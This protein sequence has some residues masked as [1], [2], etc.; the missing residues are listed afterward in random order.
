[1]ARIAAVFAVTSLGACEENATQSPPP[2]SAPA[3]RVNQ[4]NN[5]EIPDHTRRSELIG[6]WLSEG[7][8]AYEIREEPDGSVVIQQQENA[9]WTYVI[10][11]VRW[12]SDRLRFDEYAIYK[13]P[14]EL[15][16]LRTHP[17]SGVRT[18]MTLRFTDDPQRLD[19]ELVARIS[20]QTIRENGE[21]VRAP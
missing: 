17:F 14:N 2:M 11:N 12:E 5:P 4:P 20:G 7:E 15:T 16:S 1:M 10:N 8:L 19:Q 13:G 21:L 3:Q 6:Q 18:R 9:A